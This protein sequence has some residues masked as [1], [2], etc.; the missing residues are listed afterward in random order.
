MAASNHALTAFSFIGFVLVTVPLPWHLEAWNTGTCLY[1]IW[2]AIGCF[3]FFVNS[4]VW[5]GNAYN[6]SPIWCDIS[7]RLIIMVA[8][9]IP[10][11]SLCINRRLYHIAS[12][13]SVTNTKRQKRQAVMVDLAIGLGIPVLEG[14][15]QYIPQGHRYNIIEDVGCFPWIYN[16]PLAFVFVYTWPLI[17]GIVSAI[18]SGLTIRAFAK[19]RVQF[20]QLL[21]ANSNLNSNRYFRLMC[22]AGIE[23]L[24]T[25][26]LSSWV[27]YNNAANGVV[28]WKGWEDT[29]S[30]F[31]RVDQIPA[32][33]WRN[34]YATHVSFELTRWSMVVCAFIFF[35]FFGFADEARKNYRHAFSSVAKRVGYSTGSM[36]SG[37]SSTNGGKTGISDLSFK[38][39]LPSLPVFVRQETTRTTDA[40]SI[41]SYDEK[42]AARISISSAFDDS[43]GKSYSPSTSSG[44]SASSIH[45]RDYSPPR[46]PEPVVV[47]FS[48]PR[49]HHHHDIV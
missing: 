15:L 34:N 48:V 43:K 35:A 42:M 38:A 46:H 25:I 33:I 17:I 28:P 13:N 9:A 10:A 16:T 14:I 22:L 7:A 21:S 29:H 4:I 11:A 45:D 3:N 8:V 37:A 2:T 12:V 44:S 47:P 6:I 19:R 39:G 27:L 32:I 41:A 23:L 20:K 1:M 49:L 24:C 30:H 31:A 5:D 36:T 40:D 18:Y 26:P